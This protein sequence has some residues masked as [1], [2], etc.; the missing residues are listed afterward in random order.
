M[1][2]VVLRVVPVVLRGSAR[3]CKVLRVV[4]GGTT[5]SIAR[6]YVVLKEV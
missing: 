4:L 5:S 1:L 3:I 2:Q 6:R